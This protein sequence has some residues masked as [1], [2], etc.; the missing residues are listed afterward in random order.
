[1]ESVKG[2][3][4]EISLAGCGRPVI[5]ISFFDSTF[6]SLAARGTGGAVGS[7]FFT[8]PDFGSTEESETPGSGLAMG[9][10]AW[11]EV[12]NCFAIDSWSLSFDGS[13][14]LEEVF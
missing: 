4:N 13:F 3:R 1:M 14:S 9:D 10:A 11:S 6:V 5:F 7:E 2:T 12:A 8:G